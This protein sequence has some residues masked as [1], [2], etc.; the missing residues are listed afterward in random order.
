MISMLFHSGPTETTGF[1]S[2][3][4][5]VTNEVCIFSSVK[6]MEIR[7]DG[8]VHAAMNKIEPSNIMDT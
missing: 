1:F 5:R 3:N 8:L 6:R 2:G 4:F 7:D